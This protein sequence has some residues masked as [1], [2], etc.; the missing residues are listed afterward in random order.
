ML[1]V[2]NDL[3]YK[4]WIHNCKDSLDRRAITQTQIGQPC[5]WCDVTEEDIAQEDMH[6]DF[7]Y[8]PELI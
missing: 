1:T 4:F 3:K 7:L 6:D 5:N 8:N 2:D